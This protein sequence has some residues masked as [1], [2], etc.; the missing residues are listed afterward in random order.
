MFVIECIYVLVLFILYI[1]HNINNREKISVNPVNVNMSKIIGM[2][3]LKATIFY[4]HAQHCRAYHRR[5]PISLTLREH[6]HGP[7]DA[8]RRRWHINPR[9]RL[10][11]QTS[12]PAAEARPSCSP[13]EG[14]D[15]RPN[16][17][18]VRKKEGWEIIRWANVSDVKMSEFHDLDLFLDLGK[19][20][21]SGGLVFFV[22]FYKMINALMIVCITKFSKTN[23]C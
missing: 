4:P 13:S 6:K 22:L 5:R 23:R 15:W 21:V 2:F 9:P 17:S 10:P 3:T 8:V 7:S 11:R 19:L 14:S 12:S 18:E 1:N 20:S 16:T